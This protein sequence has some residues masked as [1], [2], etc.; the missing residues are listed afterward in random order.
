MG[1]FVRHPD[2]VDRRRAFMTLSSRASEAMRAYLVA[3][4]KA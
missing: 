2:P 1:L 3:A 4:R